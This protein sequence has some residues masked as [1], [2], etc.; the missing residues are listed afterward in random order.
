MGFGNPPGDPPHAT[1]HPSPVTRHP[2]HPFAALLLN[3]DTVVK[4]GALRALVDFLRTTPRAGVAGANL[5][6]PDGSHQECAFEFPGVWQPAGWW[7]RLSKSRL[8]GRY[9]RRVFERDEP[10]PIGHPLGAAFV[11]RGEA[12]SQ[13]GLL[14]EGYR[15][16]CEE[17]DWAWRMQRTGWQ[18]YCV[19][20][21][22][23][24]HY[25]GQSARQA[26]DE[27]FVNLWRSRKRLYERHHGR[28]TAAVVG[29]LV[30]LAMSR[31]ARFGASP[32]PYLEVA[33]LWR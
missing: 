13:V 15:M 19:P 21:A 4:P 24:I 3:P 11:A 16:Y 32:G 30:R 31:R 17:I 10:F 5:V 9:P 12:V 7:Q 27:A 25:G 33:R 26:R 29:G 1:R 28:L 2:S 23:V 6:N 18:A 8:N 20:R 14:D 22:E